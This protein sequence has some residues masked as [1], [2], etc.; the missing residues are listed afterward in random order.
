MKR[1][2]M[3]GLGIGIVCALLY[4]SGLLDLP[5]AR[6]LDLRFDLRGARRPAF[7]I[8][9]VTVDDD[10]LAEMDRQWPWP[11][12]YHAKVIEQIAKGNPRAIGVD[13]LFP[14]ASVDREDR[15]L[16]KAVARSKRV[17]LGSTLRSIAT[18]GGG[19]IV[20][21]REITEPPI[22]VIREGAA[23]VAF[24][25][26]DLGKDSVVRSSLLVRRHAGQLHESFAKRLY[27]LTAKEL[28]AAGGTAASRTR[29]WINFLGP[30][31]TFPTYPYYQV[32]RGE[33]DPKTFEGKVVL[34]GVSALSLHDRYPTPFAG[35]S[36][37]PTA[38][39]A[40]LK[41]RGD[42]EAHLMPGTEI[43]ANV[44]HTLLANDS[45]LRLPPI[46]Y[47]VLIV[48]VSVAVAVLAGH[49]RPLR[50]IACTLG[51]G[52]LYLIASQ[53]AFTWLNLWVEVVPVLLPLVVSA[54]TVISVNY[55]HEERVRHEYARFFSPAVARQIAE[56][57]SGLAVQ[58]KRRRITVLFSDIRDFT[59]ISEG[60]SPEDVVELL[61][62]YFNTMV[63]LVLKHGGTLD[64]YVGDA[65]MALFGAPLPQEDHAARAVR[66]AQEMIAQLPVL[67]PKWEARCGRA[68]RIGVGINTGDAVVG[69]MG[70]DH[71]REYSA[72]G[73]TVNLASRLEGVTKEFKTPIVISQYTADAV[74]ETFA[75]RELSEVR[76]KGRV[77]A[78]RVFAVEGEAGAQ[79]G[80]RP[81][82][83][84]GEATHG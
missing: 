70:A 6:T 32:Y 50:A 73:D 48:A 40:G 20:Q 71:R 68:L 52:V 44:L 11:R 3:F 10:S 75:L 67:S 81:L 41:Q 74:G 72:I 1:P 84:L 54:G 46:F 17:V 33:L 38:A 58:G 30:A 60:L 27:E 66:A 37:L 42:P 14:E 62:E 56:D 31:D 39:E 79:G 83:D 43:Q 12:S 15:Q 13:I 29:V 19:G 22:P 57:R 9:L 36:W 80:S 45:I 35:A 28:G 34:I 18:Q 47:L 7:P 64:K 53:G 51:L 4:L 63:P 25:D 21:Q 82:A 77:E 78:V 69:V 55:I 59:S 8:V 76:V 65:I 61:R 2:W 49:L 5:E 26:L 23:G 24:V 16:G